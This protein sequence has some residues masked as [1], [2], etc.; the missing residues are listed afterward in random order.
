MTWRSRPTW[1]RNRPQTGS[2]LRS[3]SGGDTSGLRWLPGKMRRSA[4]DAWPSKPWRRGTCIPRMHCRRLWRGL[5]LPSA[6]LTASA[7]N[8]S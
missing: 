6:S 3:T 7:L 2:R 8:R 1:N 5:Q 4:Y